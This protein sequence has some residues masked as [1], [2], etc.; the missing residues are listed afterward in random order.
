MIIDLA[1]L[2]QT[3]NICKIDK[4]LKFTNK[5]CL[6]TSTN[7]LLSVF[8]IQEIFAGCE[9]PGAWRYQ[10][11][12]RLKQIILIH[13][14]L[15]RNFQQ[16]STLSEQQAITRSTSPEESCSWSLSTQLCKI[17]YSTFVLTTALLA[18]CFFHCTLD[19]WFC[20]SSLGKEIIEPKR[21]N[22]DANPLAMMNIIR[23]LDWNLATRGSYTSYSHDPA[24][25]WQWLDVS[26]Q[27]VF[28]IISL[29]I[30]STFSGRLAQQTKNR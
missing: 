3:R 30:I 24:G 7:N 6:S 25:Q 27:K 26:L 10:K 5:N 2:Q 8:N 13:L 28:N 12:W 29:L 4:K 20:W 1:Y 15:Y 16:K 14:S 9:D 23:Y 18:N 21:K 22:F 19:H 17:L 11:I